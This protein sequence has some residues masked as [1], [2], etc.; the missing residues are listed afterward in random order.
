M[1][2]DFSKKQYVCDSFIHNP[3]G[4]DKSEK[5]HIHVCNRDENRTRRCGFNSTEDS[6]EN[7]CYYTDKKKKEAI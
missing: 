3:A 2:N 5:G 1:T 7:C 6:A 4:V